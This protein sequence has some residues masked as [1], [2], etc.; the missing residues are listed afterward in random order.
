[1]SPFEKIKFE[2]NHFDQVALE[3]N[4]IAEL[5]HNPNF[6]IQNI[7]KHRHVALDLGCGSG[8]LV[9]E[10]AT[11]FDYV[12]GI[13]TSYEMLS[14]AQAKRYASNILYLQ[15]H[16]EQLGLSGQFD[17]IISQN[18][19]HHLDNIEKAIDVMKSLLKPAGRLVLTDV[20]SENETPPRYIYQIG[21]VQEYIPNVI[22]YGFAIANRVFRF[23][24]SEHW[25]NH[26]A[27]DH[28]LSSSRFEEIYAQLLPN[29]I[30]PKAGHLIWDKPSR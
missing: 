5:F 29:A 23:R 21:A 15:A 28:Y 8:L 2:G 19:F 16:I 20:V 10:L 6:F 14:I 7:S 25:L 12:I 30:F 1:M 24:I 3:Y 18:T 17:Y 26:L 4:F 11:T 22:N 27:S 9:Q 13:D